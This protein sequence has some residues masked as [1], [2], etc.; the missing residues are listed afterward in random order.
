MRLDDLVGNTPLVQL[1]E[2]KNIF[3]KL[4]MFNPSGS[5]KDRV[6]KYIVEEYAKNM[7]LNEESEF[8]ISTSGNMGISLAFI[9]SIKNYKCSVFMGRNASLERKK[10]IRFYGAKLYETDTLEEAINEAKYY[11]LKDRKRILIN[12]FENMLNPLVHY[13][14]T[15]REILQNCNG[16]IDYLVSGIGSGGTISG[17][18]RKLKDYN[19]KIKVI[20]VLPVFHNNT[21]KIEGIGA[22]FV[23]KTYDE[24][25]VDDIYEVEYEE[26]LNMVKELGEKEG[27]SVGLSS[28]A[29]Y[30]VAKHIAEIN[31]DKKIV[32][33]FPD[34]IQKYLSIIK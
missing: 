27:I 4:E 26:A 6:A 30:Y 21:H 29:A 22:G 17:V 10:M 9:C 11:A 12:Q 31:K 1:K 3:A 19:Q 18:G 2:M 33:I 15:G 7:I 28:G 23:A 20:G 32:V 8:V 5:I 16:D 34:G 13:L 14:Q 25:Y 24:K